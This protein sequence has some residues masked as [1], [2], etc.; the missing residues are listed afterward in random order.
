MNNNLT[1]PSHISASHTAMLLPQ[2]VMS[3]IESWNDVPHTGHTTHSAADYAGYVRQV[4][5]D[6]LFKGRKDTHLTASAIVLS[7]DLSQTLLVFHKKALMW[8]QPGGHLEKGD[9]SVREAALREARE[10]TGVREFVS[11]IP[12]PADINV[13]QLGG[14]FSVCREHWDIGF[15]VLASAQAHLQISNESAGLRWFAVDALPEDTD[16]APRVAAAISA[17]R[18]YTS[19]RA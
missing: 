4:G 3:E 18:R 14:G 10:E 6:A 2:E 9:S 12:T 19:T 13:H 1:P 7:E 11:V 15:A 5:E 16:V 8:L 17:V